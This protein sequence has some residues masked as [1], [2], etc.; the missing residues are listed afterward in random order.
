VKIV[1]DFIRS[2]QPASYHRGRWRQLLRNGPATPLSERT[3][4]AEV[5]PLRTKRAGA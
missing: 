2:T 3:E 5:T 1:N 4:L